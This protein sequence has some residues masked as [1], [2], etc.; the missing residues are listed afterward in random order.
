MASRAIY[1]LFNFV[2][3]LS[4]TPP[5]SIETLA[6]DAEDMLYFIKSNTL[7]L[8]NERD[9]LIEKL[10]EMKSSLFTKDK[11]SI[12]KIDELVNKIKDLSFEN[13]EDINKLLL[14]EQESKKIELNNS[15]NL[16]KSFIDKVMEIRLFYIVVPF[17]VGLIAL[18]YFIDI[19]TNFEI[20]TTLDNDPQFCKIFLNKSDLIITILKKYKEFRYLYIYGWTNIMIDQQ[21]DIVEALIK[22]ILGIKSIENIYDAAGAETV[23]KLYD[24]F[25][26]KPSI[27]DSG[28]GDMNSHIE[29]SD[30]TRILE[31]EVLA[32][33]IKLSKLR[34]K[35]S[36]SRRKRSKSRRRRS[37]SKRRRS[38]SRRRR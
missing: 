13:F 35:R 10:L 11:D 5:T 7:K 12:E 14:F 29:L 27:N 3:R 33:K 19:G 23:K 1:D 9:N 34:R 28:I 30:L 24:A 18:I 38:K 4:L 17:L 16:K 15:Q 22:Y 20:C 21:F 6:E 26:R 31:N 36:K 32:N 25:T 37:K 8:L 2:Y